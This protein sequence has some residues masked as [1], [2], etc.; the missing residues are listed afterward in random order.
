VIITKEIGLTELAVSNEGKT[1][2]KLI[3]RTTISYPQKRKK[4]W[5]KESTKREARCGLIDL[6][7]QS[8]W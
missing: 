2:R 1:E 4:K 3:F 6:L 7:W 8:L 5:Q